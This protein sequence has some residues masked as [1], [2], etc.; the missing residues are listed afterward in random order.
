MREAVI[1]LANRQPTSD[2]L[3]RMRELVRE[4]MRD[5][6]FGL[7]T[8]LFYVPAHSPRFPKWWSC[9]KL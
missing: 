2:E 1:G 8:G 3:E 9:K 4:D 6:A 5:G 7:S